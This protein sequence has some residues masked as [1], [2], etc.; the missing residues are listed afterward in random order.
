MLEARGL[1]TSYG[2]SQVLFGVDLAVAAGEVV[3]LLGRNG[4]GKTTTV[5]SIMGLTRPQAGEVYFAG[6]RLTGLPAYRAAQAGLGLVPEG[7]QIFPNLRVRENLVATA[8]PPRDAS[9]QVAWTL[10]RVFALFP[11]LAERAGNL[12]S[13][14]S[15]GE[16]QMLAIARALMARPKLLLLDEPSMGLAPVLVREIFKTLCQLNAGGLTIFLVEQNLRQALRIAHHA[17]V[18]ENGVITLC[19]ASADLLD[20]PKVLE[21]YLGG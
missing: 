17:Y 11:R 21:A 2:T 6:V 13:Q 12:G 1:E 5:R 20:N 3:T 8:R 16:Q 18:M 7:R 10:E 19:G 14:L 9:S 4:M 15:G